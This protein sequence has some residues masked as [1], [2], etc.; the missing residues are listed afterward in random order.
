MTI[1]IER[2]FPVDVTRTNPREVI[3]LIGN[4]FTDGSQRIIVVDDPE[5]RDIPQFQERIAGVWEIGAATFSNTGF[6]IDDI[7]QSI[8]LDLEGEFIRV[9][10]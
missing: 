10:V 3:Y 7:T 9:G 2:P 6:I 4:E 1:V 5:F 8:A